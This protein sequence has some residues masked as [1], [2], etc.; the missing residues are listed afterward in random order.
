MDTARLIAPDRSL[1]YALVPV[2]SEL[3]LEAVLVLL[4]LPPEVAGEVVKLFTLESTLLTVPINY[5]RPEPHNPIRSK[6][7][8]RQ[9]ARKRAAGERW[10]Y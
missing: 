3:P 6:N 9:R 4:L 5:G 10:S 8:G 1:E 2:K 7:E